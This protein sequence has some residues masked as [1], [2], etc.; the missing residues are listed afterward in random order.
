MMHLDVRIWLVT[1]RSPKS[2]DEKKLFSAPRRPCSVR[3][4]D[5][6]SCLPPWVLRYV[7]CTAYWLQTPA[8]PNHDVPFAS[9]PNAALKS[10]QTIKIAPLGSILE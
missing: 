6:S 3:N 10:S 8:R 5:P 9:S 7:K 1:P 2:I 4:L